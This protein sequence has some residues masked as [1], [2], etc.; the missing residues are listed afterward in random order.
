MLRFNQSQR[1]ALSDT[2]RELA[3]VVAGILVLSQFI[4]EEPPSIRLIFGG[5]VAWLG[6][7][8]M[9]L[10]LLGENSNEPDR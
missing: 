6:L 10:V 7:N 5:V 2:L 3:N 9:A 1:T 8:S 4:G